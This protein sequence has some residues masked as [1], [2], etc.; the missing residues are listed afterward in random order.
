VSIIVI[1]ISL[2]IFAAVFWMIATYVPPGNTRWILL[3]VVAIV[4]IIWLLKVIGVAIPT[5][6]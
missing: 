3:A 5:H 6:T 4:L 1:L 2:L